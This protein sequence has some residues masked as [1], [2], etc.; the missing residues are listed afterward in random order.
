KK[1]VAREKIARP[2]WWARKDSRPLCVND[3]R[4]DTI[5]LRWIALLARLRT[6]DG[7]SA[8]G[9]V[10]T[11]GCWSNLPAPASSESCSPYTLHLQSRDPCATRQGDSR[12]RP[13]CPP[14]RRATH[15]LSNIEGRP[16]RPLSTMEMRTR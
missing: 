5:S 8:Y 14:Q 4:A 3:R 12:S 7:V 13:S 16:R 10:D 6:P 2:S 15:S 11:L 1:C 9:A